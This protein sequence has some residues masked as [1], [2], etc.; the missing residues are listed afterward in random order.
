MDWHRVQKVRGSWNFGAT[1]ILDVLG[2]MITWMLRGYLQGTSA[3]NSYF[4]VSEMS[5]GWVANVVEQ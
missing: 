5:V 4:D 2:G 1:S 3:Q